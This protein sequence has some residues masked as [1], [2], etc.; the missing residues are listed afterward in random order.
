MIK[1][2]NFRNKIKKLITSSKSHWSI[3]QN[4][5]SFNISF[6]NDNADK[7]TIWAEGYAS[8]IEFHVS[9]SKRPLR[10]IKYEDV[11]NMYII[12][13]YGNNSVLYIELKNGSNII[14]G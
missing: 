11:F 12:E 6:Y 13:K 9:S 2:K 1:Y 8:C 4:T 3:Y 7:F 14:I 5:N 10:T